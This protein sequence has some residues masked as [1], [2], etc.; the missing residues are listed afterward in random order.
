MWWF[1][2][3]GSAV[4]LTGCA[5][6]LAGAPVVSD[7]SARAPQPSSAPAPST[8]AAPPDHVGTRGRAQAELLKDNDFRIAFD[9]VRRLRVALDFEEIQFGLLRV[10][11]G[12]GFATVSSARYNLEHLYRAYRVA[13][14]RREDTV[15]E[16]WKEGTKVGEVTATDVLLGP[17]LTA[18]R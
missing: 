11:L 6:A 16:L 13:S 18:P 1:A 12:P 17:E 2:L 3:M 15:I 9:D 10:T 5:N 4:L 8:V 7:S 14:Y